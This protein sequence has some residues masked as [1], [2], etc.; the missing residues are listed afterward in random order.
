MSEGGRRQYENLYANIRRGIQD[1]RENNERAQ[2]LMQQYQDSQEQQDS[3]RTRRQEVSR[4]TSLMRRALDAMARA[5]TRADLLS[6]KIIPSTKNHCITV[7]SDLSR[8]REYLIQYQSGSR[9]YDIVQGYILQHERML[10][11]LQEDIDE[12]GQDLFNQQS[13]M[14]TLVSQMEQYQRVI[15]G[16][17]EDSA[18]LAP[19]IEPEPIVDIPVLLSVPPEQEEDDNEDEENRPG[20]LV[21]INPQFENRRGFGHLIRW[22][23]TLPSELRRSGRPQRDSMILASGSRVKLW[24]Q[25]SG[26]TLRIERDGEVLVEDIPQNVRDNEYVINL[27]EREWSALSGFSK[28]D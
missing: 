26:K 2:A 19:I 6:R 18:E 22:Q 5:E 13:S 7:E 25:L 14:E 17:V 21:V 8:L 27:S 28:E 9:R 1:T 20:T 16:D 4:A 15:D 24:G 12:Q 11:N 10:V 23:D 3:E